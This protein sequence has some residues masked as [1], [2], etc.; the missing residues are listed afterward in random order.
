MS[1][2]TLEEVHREHADRLMTLPGV[3]GVGIGETGGKPCLLVLVDNITPEV[4]A[5][6]PTILNGYSVVVERSGK[7]TAHD[8]P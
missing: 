2:K 6:I 5:K 1:D 3:V 8:I 7:F 4:R